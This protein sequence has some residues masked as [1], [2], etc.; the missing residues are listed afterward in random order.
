MNQTIGAAETA[1][2][3]LEQPEHVKNFLALFSIESY[4]GIKQSMTGGEYGS[5]GRILNLARQPSIDDKFCSRAVMGFIKNY[6]GYKRVVSEVQYETGLQLVGAQIAKMFAP[7]DPKKQALEVAF[8]DGFSFRDAVGR[9][10]GKDIGLADMLLDHQVNRVEGFQKRII[11][12]EQHA[13]IHS[14]GRNAMRSARMRLDL[15]MSKWSSRRRLYSASDKE[16]LRQASVNDLLT[17]VANLVYAPHERIARTGG[18]RALEITERVYEFWKEQGGL[19]TNSHSADPH[20]DVHPRS[21][22]NSASCPSSVN[23]QFFDADHRSTAPWLQVVT[24]ME[25]RQHLQA[26]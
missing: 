15:P 24:A 8:P 1:E 17:E 12:A 5:L 11:S 23:R 19:P 4:R 21:D 10:D 16:Q 25:N 13:Q 18:Q 14:V 26:V 2:N 22:N 20:F 3:G 9:H 7:I 6:T